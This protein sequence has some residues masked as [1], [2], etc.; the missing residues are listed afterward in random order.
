MSAERVKEW[1]GKIQ[2]AMVKD[3]HRLSRSL[4]KIQTMLR[5]GKPVDKA[6][7][8]IQT[9]LAASLQLAEDR[10]QAMPRI[11]YPQQLPVSQLKDDILS[12]LLKHQV[13]IVAG[14]TGSG[15]TTQIPK[16]CLEAGRGVF[17]KIG[18]TQ[19]RRLAARTVAQRIAEELQVAMG[20]QVGYQVRFTDHSSPTTL[21][22]L[23]TDGILLAETQHDRYLSQYD[24][25][26]ID[27][28]HE[29]SLNIDFLPLTK[30]ELSGQTLFRGLANVPSSFKGFTKGVII[31]LLMEV[32]HH[33]E[34][35]ALMVD[36]RYDMRF[37]QSRRVI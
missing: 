30:Q 6:I 33:K 13:V 32:E 17:G 29:R 36:V 21:V 24:T 28:A 12:A 26:I 8:R 19:P 18:H 34:V 16:I 15:K 35:F 25:L 5:Q 22:K 4:A 31:I 2:Q 14:E 37:S 11:D 20:E 7:A 3:R 9:Q 27:E 23:M 1:S 10:K